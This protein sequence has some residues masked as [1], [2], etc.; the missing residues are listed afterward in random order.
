MVVGDVRIS[1]R[2]A[3]V[4]DRIVATGSLVLRQVG[5][6]RAG[7]VACHRF[8]DNGRVDAAA[9]IDELSWRTAS[10][11]A[12]RRVVAVQDTTEINFSGRDRGRHGLGRAGNGK[13]LGFFIHPVV[14]VDAEDEAVLGLVDGAIWTRDGGAKADRRQR[15]FEDKESRRWLDGARAAS[16]R[17]GT[18]RQVIVVGDRES[19]IYPAFARRPD[20]VELI[21]RVA[22]N[23]SLAS[24]ERVFD[25]ALEA[26]GELEVAVGAKPG[27]KARQ[28]KLRL[29]AGP[30]TLARPRNGAEREDPESLTLNVV[31]TVE[32]APP[33]G[34]KPL[35]WR[36]YTTLPV[37]SPA[38]AADVVR[39]YRLRWR[40]EEVFR[41]LKSD[42]LKLEDTQVEAAERLFKLAALRLGLCRCGRAPMGGLTCRGKPWRSCQR[43]TET[44]RRGCA[45]KLAKREPWRRLRSIMPGEFRRY[46]LE[47]GARLWRAEIVKRQARLD[48]ERAAEVR[49][50]KRR[51]RAHA[52]L[53]E[54]QAAF[55]RAYVLTGNTAGSYREAGYTA[56]PNVAKV[57]G[58]WMRRRPHVKRAIAEL[59]AAR[60]AERDREIER[61]EVDAP[62]RIGRVRDVDRPVAA[63]ALA[64]R[65]DSA[66]DRGAV[67]LR[68]RA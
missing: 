57:E 44:D 18:A 67:C 17:L 34:A 1:N 36:L 46:G 3:W 2:G 4:M 62:S 39:L 66:P 68:R 11:C 33:K 23:R 25:A 42:G 13:A 19:D 10:A 29:G 22:Q 38:A 41:V 55:V 50:A 27:Q 37:D 64:D 31:E 63:A 52:P 51:A 30:V 49:A 16:A 54:R 7:E 48:L 59:R 14:A 12:G 61:A 20:D 15:R 6:D 26:Y 21:A 58:Y 5:G 9:I 35:H 8:L 28:A 53:N 45:A 40:I 60:Q 56:R 32:I 47:L 43:C 65:T 24:G